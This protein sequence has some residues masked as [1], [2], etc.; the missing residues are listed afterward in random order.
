[1]KN[2]S[3]L[4]KIKIVRK[5]NVDIQVTLITTPGILHNHKENRSYFNE[6]S[7]VLEFF[8]AWLQMTEP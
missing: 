8:A 2:V 5:D 4:L 6:L 7:I 1:M 3:H